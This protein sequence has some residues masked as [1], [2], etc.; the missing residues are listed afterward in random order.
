MNDLRIPFFMGFFFC[1][2]LKSPKNL[3]PI[4]ERRTVEFLGSDKN[5]DKVKVTLCLT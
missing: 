1:L 4:V 3:D 5:S 2:K